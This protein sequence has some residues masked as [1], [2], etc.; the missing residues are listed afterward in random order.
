MSKMSYTTI[1]FVAETFPSPRAV[2]KGHPMIVKG[3]KVHLYLSE[4]SGMTRGKVRDAIASLPI[5]VE[6]ISE[7]AVLTV[8]IAFAQDNIH[9]NLVQLFWQITDERDPTRVRREQQLYQEG[10]RH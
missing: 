1:R 10:T 4:M 8:P 6:S 3:G 7:G 9:V 2:E 5:P